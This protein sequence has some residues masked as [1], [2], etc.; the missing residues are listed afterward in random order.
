MEMNLD[1]IIVIETFEEELVSKLVN[2]NIPICFIDFYIN[3][4]QINGKFDI[5]ETNNSR[6]VY[7]LVSELITKFNISDFS[8]VGDITHCLSFKDRYIGMVTALLSHNIS[9]DKSLDILKSDNFDY[10]NTQ[11]IKTEIL[12][13]KKNPQCYVCGNDFIAR[14]LIN[15]LKELK[16]NVPGDCLVVGFDNAIES[17][18]QHPSITTIGINKEQIGIET[19][20]SLIHRIENPDTVNKMISLETK[21]IR[22]ESTNK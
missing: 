22:R 13:L 5:I 8:F 12:K 3:P 11:I 6:S 18:F 19:V 15:A 4:H 1:G 20:K 2:L 16:I 14:T 7:Q 10:G 9:H 21:L 17:I